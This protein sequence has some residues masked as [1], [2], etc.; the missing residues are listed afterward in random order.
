MH[1]VLCSEQPIWQEMVIDRTLTPAGSENASEGN[2]GGKN[3]EYFGVIEP[4]RVDQE[5]KED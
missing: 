5:L 4:D 1:L 2:A 3:V